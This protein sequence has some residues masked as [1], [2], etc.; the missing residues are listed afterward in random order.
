MPTPIKPSDDKYNYVFE[1]WHKE[2]TD[3]TEDVVYKAQFKRVPKGNPSNPDT[4]NPG[5]NKP[6]DSD[7][8]DTD[9]PGS[10]TPGSTE[11]PGID[12]STPGADGT[13]SGNGN[14]NADATSGNANAKS[15]AIPSTGDMA[16]TV[17]ALFLLAGCIALAGVIVAAKKRKRNAK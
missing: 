13:Q 16:G 15:D 9:N 1:S 5:G 7:K 12:A 2:I 6:G 4:D 11:K 17:G 3:A 10:S 8:P 14:A